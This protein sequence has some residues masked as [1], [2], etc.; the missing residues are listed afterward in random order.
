[1][2]NGRQTKLL[3]SILK[4]GF[5]AHQVE[6][7][8]VC[9]REE[10]NYWERFYIDVHNT[11]NTDHGLN[12]QN[13][14]HTGGTLSEES[15]AKLRRPK[16]PEVL[17]RIRANFTPRPPISEETREKHRQRMLGNTH[18]KGIRARTRPMYCKD[19]DGI[20]L[21]FLCTVDCIEAMKVNKHAIYTNIKKKRTTKGIAFA[22]TIEELDE[23]LPP[24][25]RIPHQGQIVFSK[26][27]A[28]KI[29]TH[30][31]LKAARRFTG[32][33]MKTI[34]LCAEDGRLNR[35]FQFSYSEIFKPIP[36]TVRRIAPKHV[37]RIAVYSKDI[38][39]NLGAYLSIRH[40]TIVTGVSACAIENAAIKGILSKQKYY[41]SFKPF[42]A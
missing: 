11:F 36:S 37:R 3:H 34:K 21:K 18:L 9:P 4:Y 17:A 23:M 12:L 33:D 32:V 25:S 39:G 6:I 20:I 13:G 42:E 30:N 22:Y 2:K 19:K 14:G 1:M 35:G 41:F 7:I 5:E 16:S 40:G 29:D 38:H 31:S 8:V 28:G 26:D 24:P 10:L 15:K 27:K